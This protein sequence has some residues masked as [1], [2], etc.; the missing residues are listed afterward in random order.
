MRHLDPVIDQSL[1]QNGNMMVQH[2]ELGS[3]RHVSRL[4]SLVLL[5]QTCILGLEL[6]NLGILVDMPGWL[7]GGRRL[8][9]LG[10]RS[11]PILCNVI[12]HL[13]YPA[14]TAI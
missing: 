3:R 8:Y 5:L 14:Q 7:R 12:P 4:E 13:I 11:S 2:R 6:C 9:G 10:G 1:R